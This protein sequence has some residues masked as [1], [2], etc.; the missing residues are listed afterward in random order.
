MVRK[1]IAHLARDVVT[2]ATPFPIGTVVLAEDGGSAG[3]LGGRA[4]SDFICL[5]RVIEMI[6]IRHAE[7]I[8]WFHE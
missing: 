2:V 5:P 3:H 1:L 4:F 7:W 6:D 8:D